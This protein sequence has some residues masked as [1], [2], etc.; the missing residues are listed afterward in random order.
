[1]LFKT[2]GRPRKAESEEEGRTK[3][4]KK[5][6]IKASRIQFTGLT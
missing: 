6:I 5:I 2:N 4:K 3:L 1:V